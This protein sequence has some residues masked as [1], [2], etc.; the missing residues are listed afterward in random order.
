MSPEYQDGDFV[1]LIKFFRGKIKK[2]DVIVFK[3]Q[4]YGT[5][6]KA[7]EKITDEGVYVLGTGENSLDSRRLGP[8]NPLS[9]QGRVIWHIRRT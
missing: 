2:G 8:V 1:L 7:V 5:L 3:H 9:V 4:L 6:I